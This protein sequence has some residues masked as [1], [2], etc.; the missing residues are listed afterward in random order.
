MTVEGNSSSDNILSHAGEIILFSR[1]QLMNTAENIYDSYKWAIG[2][3]H[4]LLLYTFRAD[5]SGFLGC[6]HTIE[7]VI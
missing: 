4:P 7:P 5:S 6:C 3:L 1:S 2:F